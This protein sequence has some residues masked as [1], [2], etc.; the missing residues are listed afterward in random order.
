MEQTLEEW[1]CL[2]AYKEARE[3]HL[4]SLGL[5][6]ERAL[7]VNRDG[8]RC[9]AERL[10]RGLKRLAARAGVE[11]L[12]LH[13]FRHTCASD[14]LE[15]GASVAEVQEVLGHRTISTTMRYLQVADPQLHGAAELH[16]VDAMLREE[17]HNG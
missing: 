4:A 2:E 17:T 16:P 9:H 12:T 7:F 11:G 10:S 13:R 3:E 5:T 8:V 15:A 6:H 14:L 1:R